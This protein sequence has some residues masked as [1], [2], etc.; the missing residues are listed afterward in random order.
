MQLAQ[1]LEI[2][3]RYAR[4]DVNRTI[5]P[6][7]LMYQ[8]PPEGYFA[9]GKSGLDAILH[10]YVTEE[11]AKHHHPLWQHSNPRSRK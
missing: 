3:E 5:A 1:L 7:D 6:D 11:W 8:G 2:Q 9:V 4:A 10:G